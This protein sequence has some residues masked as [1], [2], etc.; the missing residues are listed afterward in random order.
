MNA[1]KDGQLLE[2]VRAGKKID[3]TPI[4][5]F[6]CHLGASSDFYYI[7]KNSV[8]ETVANMDRIGIDHIVSFPIT[9]SS[10]PEPS[11]N[12]H[13]EV[14]KQYPERISVLTYLH[15]KFAEDWIPLLK[16]GHENGSRGVKLISGY[17]GV[18]EKNMDWSPVFEYAKDKNWVILNHDWGTTDILA[19]YAKNFP[20][21]NFI[22]GHA[23]YDYDKVVKNHDNVYMCTCASFVTPAYASIDHLWKTLP[24]EKILHGSDCQDLDFCTAIGPLA[25]SKIIPEEDKEKILG[26]NAENLMS[27]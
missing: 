11:N 2:Y 27:Q 6:H 22:I 16:K 4:I 7:P 23:Y 8:E 25:Y 12:Y 1:D 5:D 17:Q 19:D 26:I 10:D 13:Y 24:V 14:I 20:T 3:Y 18:D 21:V 9:V 15:A